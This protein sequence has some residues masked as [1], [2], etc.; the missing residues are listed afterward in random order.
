M[1]ACGIIIV[2]ARNRCH[3]HRH[4]LAGQH[5]TELATHRVDNRLA[6]RGARPLKAADLHGARHRLDG[7]VQCRLHEKI[8]RYLQDSQQ[9]DEK[10]HREDREFQRYRAAA[11]ALQ[12]SPGC[13]GNN[14]S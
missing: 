3:R 8:V 7:A 11:A 6:V 10:R 4:L 2:P 14:A 5:R 1:N 12:A 9:H 13:F